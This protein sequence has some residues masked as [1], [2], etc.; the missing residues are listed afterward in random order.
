MTSITQGSTNVYADLESPDSEQML[1]KA[2]LAEKI[3]QII[4]RRH[5][6]QTDAASILGIPQSKLSLI[7]R[8]QFRG[9]SE[10]KMLECLNRLGRDV[11]IIVKKAPRTK[12]QGRISVVF[13]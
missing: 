11:Q 10:L 13:A 2:Q 8:G 4:Q 6:T 3:S 7:L 1:L 12:P 9:V 5:L